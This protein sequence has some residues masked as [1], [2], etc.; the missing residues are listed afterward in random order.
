VRALQD[1]QHEQ[2]LDFMAQH[3]CAIAPQVQTLLGCAP[4]RAARRLRE[5]QELGYARSQ[6]IF[7]ARPSTW[8]ITPAGLAAVGSRLGPPRL[9]LSQCGHDLGLGWLWLAARDGSFGK[10]G[11]VH[12]ERS[13]RSHDARGRF[14]QEP[15]GVGLGPTGP[16]GGEQRHYPD[17]LLTTP[18]GRRIAVE[19]ELSGKGPQRLAG[20][21]LAYAADARIDAVMYLVSDRRLAGRIERAAGAAGIGELVRVQLMSRSIQ[22]APEGGHPVPRRASLCSRERMTAARSPER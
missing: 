21:M 11:A 14:T 18:A 13:M 6:R 9:H 5:L 8:R 15:L 22:G 19:L 12:S 20:I 16:R 2:V 10:L 7:A 1:P 17:L 4:A 3:R